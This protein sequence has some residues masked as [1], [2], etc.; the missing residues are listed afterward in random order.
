MLRLLQGDVGSGKTVVALLAMADVV[1]AGRQS[2]M[3]A[4]RSSSPA[5]TTSASRLWLTGG[6]AALMTGRDKAAARAPPSRIGR[7]ASRL[8][9]GTHALFQEGVASPISGSRWST[10]SIGLASASGSRPPP[11]AKPSISW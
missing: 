11:R 5:S 2:V 9:I 7:M 6:Q 3:I 8:A 1:E 4:R 10:S